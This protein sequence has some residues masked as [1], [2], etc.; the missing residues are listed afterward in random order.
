M[1]GIRIARLIGMV[2][3]TGVGSA[4]DGWCQTD[5]VS[6][7]VA[8]HQLTSRVFENSRSIRVLMPPGYHDPANAERRYPVLYLNDGIMAFRP[9]ALGLE[10]T[11]HRLIQA[12]SIEPII[13]VGIDNGGS[14][15]KTT[16]PV[17]DRA[18]EFLPYADAGFGP[19]RYQPV[20]PSP[21][22][23]RYPAFLIGEV[24]PFVE[25]RYRVAPG[26]SKAG[27]GGF[28]Y[29]AV[30]ALYTVLSRPGVFGRAVLES[31]PLWIGPSAELMRDARAAAE[32]PAL[33]YLGSGSEES[34]EREIVAE[35]RRL[36]DSLVGFIRRAA[37]STRTEV[38]EAPGGKH[39]PASW[40]DRLARALIFLY[41]AGRS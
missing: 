8:I 11:A 18:N 38:L 9:T 39:D 13:V 19:H 29:G 1:A 14:T 24:M 22:G 25:A 26:W 4:L 32:W 7:N 27:V 12:D 16:D 6:P 3:I 28:S 35:G 36:R 20:P 34:P 30:A 2:L 23:K 15:D 41:G 5:A 17:R 21:V 10:A 37:P 31:T 40:R 33:V